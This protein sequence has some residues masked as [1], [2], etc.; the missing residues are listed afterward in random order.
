MGRGGGRPA[1]E[2][3]TAGGGQ[4]EGVRPEGASDVTCLQQIVSC[5]KP[6]CTP[7]A[8]RPGEG[9]LARPA[10]TQATALPSQRSARPSLTSLPHL[11]LTRDAP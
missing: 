8:G 2:G 3:P 6:A 10:Q 7:A 4:E 11:T 9:I 5:P 1:K